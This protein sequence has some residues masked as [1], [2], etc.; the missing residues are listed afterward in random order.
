MFV[1]FGK[2]AYLCISKTIMQTDMEE[3]IMQSIRNARESW[4][5]GKRKAMEQE[6]NRVEGLYRQAKELCPRI[7]ELCDYVNFAFE[8]GYSI[9]H[10]LYPDTL[11]HS[12]AN[13]VADS[14]RKLGFYAKDASYCTGEQY[15][16]KTH[17]FN[18]EHRY[19]YVGRRYRVDIDAKDLIA[20]GND[21]YWGEDSF[22]TLE[23]H[24]KE[25]K[26]A[27]KMLERFL[28]DFQGFDR[29]VMMFI[30]NVDKFD[31]VF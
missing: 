22:S 14:D 13:L 24:T 6:R 17:Q 2:N 23:P 28:D 18:R 10:C 8:N 27:V 19:S 15:C 12:Y 30:N 11:R 31:C 9:E 25:W 5:D 1:S 21:F 20:D 16:K 7:A 26:D 29:N 4:I 3:K